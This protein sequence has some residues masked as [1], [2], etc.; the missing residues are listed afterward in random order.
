MLARP[1]TTKVPGCSGM[2][3]GSPRG[4]KSDPIC[5]GMCGA[6]R[7]GGV[8]TPS[9]RAVS[10]AQVSS[11]RRAFPPVGGPLAGRQDRKAPRCGGP[12][13]RPRGPRGRQRRGRPRCH[14]GRGAPGTGAGVRERAGGGAGAELSPGGR[15]A[16]PRRPPA[17]RP[18]RQAR[19]GVWEAGARSCPR[20]LRAGQSRRLA[21]GGGSAAQPPRPGGGRGLTLPSPAGRSRLLPGALPRAAGPRSSARRCRPAG[22]PG[23]SL[24]SGCPGRGPVE[25]QVGTELP[26]GSSGQFLICALS[27]SLRTLASPVL[28]PSRLPASHAEPLGFPAAASALLSFPASQGQTR[29]N[30]CVFPLGVLV[31]CSCAS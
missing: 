21:G 8:R 19:P 27:R 22:G 23:L 18:R 4:S 29:N 11:Y 26:A 14:C 15:A 6:W 30:R 3:E 25:Q 17:A 12:E 28:G 31:C 24:A 13:T 1:P 7:L 10:C 2:A 9:P 16:R 20:V 5:H